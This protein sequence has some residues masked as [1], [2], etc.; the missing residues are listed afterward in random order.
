MT[1]YHLLLS[2]S[3]RGVR[4]WSECGMLRY[5]AANGVLESADIEQL[6]Q[7]KSEILRLL[8]TSSAGGGSAA[9]GDALARA[10]PSAPG[11]AGRANASGDPPAEVAGGACD[12]VPTPLAAIPP[13][14][15]GGAGAGAA[16]A[17]PSEFA[18]PA[19]LAGGSADPVADATEVEPD[20]ADAGEAEPDAAAAAGPAPP[21]ARD[22]AV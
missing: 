19:P 5:A 8:A 21:P 17:P 20:A 4:L 18:A 13:G 14:G 1:A 16:T 10:A 15:D 12:P 2:L 3:Q 6:K 11:A 9:E 22:A 7:H